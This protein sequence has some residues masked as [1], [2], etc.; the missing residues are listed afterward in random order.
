MWHQRLRDVPRERGDGVPGT[1]VRGV[2]DEVA[3]GP[4][5]SRNRDE[6]VRQLGEVGAVVTVERLV[7][8]QW[9]LRMAD[10]GHVRRRGQAEVD[11]SDVEAIELPSV[12]FDDHGIG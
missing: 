3:A 12:A 8:G 9:I 11:G 6:D 1:D 4:Q 2:D 5:A 10:G 7:R